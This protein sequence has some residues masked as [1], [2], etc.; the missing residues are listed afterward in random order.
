[1]E[2]EESEERDEERSAPQIE[3]GQ[4]PNETYENQPFDEAMALT[5]ESSV[6]DESDPD[7]DT[8]GPGGNFGDDSHLVTNQS[9]DE[10]IEIS[11][12][13]TVSP[14]MQSNIHAD[15]DD[16]AQDYDA[17]VGGAGGAAAGP[18]LNMNPGSDTDSDSDTEDSEGDLNK[19]EFDDTDKPEF[20]PIE[21]GY[22]P[23]DYENLECSADVKDLF[24]YISRYSA[25]RMELE[26]ALKPFIPEYIPAVGDIDAF[27]RIPR[28]DL[29]QG[30]ED[31]LGLTVL[32]EPAAVQTDRAVLEMQLRAFTKQSG[33][34]EQQVTSIHDAANNPEQIKKWIQ[35]VEELHSNKPDSSIAFTRPMPD[36]ESLMQVWPASFEEMLSQIQL[37]PPHLDCSVEEYAKICCAIL[38]I[39]VQDNVIHSIHM[40]CMLYSEFKHNQHFGDHDH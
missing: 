31:P 33:L 36:L 2:H 19:D 21:G 20:K 22:D 39:P 30:T 3:P 23:A 29:A 35:S 10:A 9:Y 16:E 37:P 27:I 12:A 25:H 32:D 5:D 8:Q 28:P 18:G 13:S 14:G 26:S 40:M 38:D 11:D 34:A 7:L 4:N 6:E 1:M 17:P 15:S 24:M